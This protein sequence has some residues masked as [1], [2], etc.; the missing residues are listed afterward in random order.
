MR[1]GSP[2]GRRARP[3]LGPMSAQPVHEQD[4][5]D[6]V[7]IHDLLPADE[8]AAFLRD[9]RAALTDARD[10]V[11]KYQRVR[12]VLAGWRMTADA[13][14]DPAYHAALVEARAAEAPG[15]TPGEVEALRLAG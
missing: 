2:S 6:P 14:H 11:A 13:H 1:Q 3:T 12:R 5:F 8:Q 4:P 9:Y 15:M 7:L 10:D